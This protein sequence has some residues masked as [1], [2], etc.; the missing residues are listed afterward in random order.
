MPLL[1]LG[2]LTSP[3]ALFQWV[4]NEKTWENLENFVRLLTVG[5]NMCP[6]A[7]TSGFHHSPDG[8]V[9]AHCHSHQNGQQVRCFL[10]FYF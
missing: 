7:S 10:S 5:S 3:L 8:I 1:L 2:V 6:V 9:P 4:D